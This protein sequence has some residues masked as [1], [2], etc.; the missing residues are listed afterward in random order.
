VLEVARTVPELFFDVLPQVIPLLLAHSLYLLES[1][2]RSATI[3]GVVG[4][5]GIGF[6]L[7]DRMQISAWQEVTTVVLL[8]L[9]T[10]AAIDAL[11][12][13]LRVRLMGGRAKS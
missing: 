3:L 1:N 7:M 12:R 9:V 5:G 10:V 11:S 8:I 2:V 13:A 4:M 6:F